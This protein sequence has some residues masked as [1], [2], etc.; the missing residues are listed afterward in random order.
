VKEELAGL[1]KRL[2]AHREKYKD[3]LNSALNM[4][5]NDMA[6][7][8]N[9]RFEIFIKDVEEEA[10]GNFKQRNVIMLAEGAL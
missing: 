3:A 4:L 10:K 5:Q 6:E 8:L 2:E 1:A 9:N 7:I